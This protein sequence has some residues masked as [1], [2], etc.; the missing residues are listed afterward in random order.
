[1]RNFGRLEFSKEIDRFF[2]LS[3]ASIAQSCIICLYNK[4][5]PAIYC[6]RLVLSGEISEIKSLSKIVSGTG[7]DSADHERSRLD[8]RSALTFPETGAD[9]ADHGRSGLDGMSVLMFPVTGADSA[10]HWRS[11][12]DEISLP[13]FP[14][15]G[16]NRPFTLIL[17]TTGSLFQSMFLLTHPITYSSS[18]LLSFP[19][20]LPISFQSS[21]YIR[22]S[23]T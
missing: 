4:L 14:V 1:M 21:L 18:I 15:T 23:Y 9:S 20:R 22:E 10:D 13:T 7:A 5:W 12:V 3:H 17:E 8:G 2:L 16:V 19:P 11:G 6:G